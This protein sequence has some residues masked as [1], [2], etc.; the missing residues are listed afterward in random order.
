MNGALPSMKNLNKPI[1][2][3]KIAIAF[4]L[5]LLVGNVYSQQ[6]IRKV[7]IGDVVKMIDTS[8][9]PI[10]VNFWATWCAPCVHE[11]P[12]FESS[13]AELKDK[14]VKLVLV[15]LDFKSDFPDKI[16]AF[17]KSKG[18]KAS[19]LWLDET[20]A[21]LFCPLIDNKWSGSIPATLM[22]NNKKGYR[23]FY[24]EQ[25]PEMKLKQELKKLVE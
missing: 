12:W 21:D 14:N 16:K 10:V 24:G 25:V 23:Q 4:L 18:Y 5:S 8:T 15:S 20:D 22:V 9:V 17:V 3:K 7:K 1:E 13:V 11:I 19:I 2:M 6:Q